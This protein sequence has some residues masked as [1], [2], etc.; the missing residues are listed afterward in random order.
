LDRPSEEETF[1]MAKEF[2]L[3]KGVAL[4]LAHPGSQPRV[5]VFSHYIYLRLHFP[6]FTKRANGKDGRSQEMNF[7]I[8]KDFII[9]AHYVTIITLYDVGKMVEKANLL[10]RNPYTET[11][12][13]I[14]FDL[15]NRMYS[16][17]ASEL[18]NNGNS[19]RDIEERVFAG[20]EKEMVI[21]VSNISRDIIDLRR[22]LR[23]HGPVLASFAAAFRKLFDHEHEFELESLR[24]KYEE[25]ASELEGNR[26]LMND[27]KET[28]ISLLSTKTNE[29][30]KMLSVMGFIMFPLTFVAAVFGM[31]TKT[32]PI[33]GDLNDFWLIMGIMAVVFVFLWGYLTRKGWIR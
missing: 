26:E 22:D 7:V 28:N 9:T 1:A 4:E 14:V 6:I 25:L 5:D 24:S 13:K 30:I 18:K 12:Q 29:A 32:M 3:G 17:I 33:V 16:K 2:N 20:K 21:E 23:S 19:L 11:P 8:G 10:G 15:I 31:N 27:L